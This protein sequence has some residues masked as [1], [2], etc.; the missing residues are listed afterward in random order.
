VNN[1]KEQHQK[2][3]SRLDKSLNKYLPLRGPTPSNPKRT[4][5]D[6][7]SYSRQVV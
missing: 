3:M 4:E 7:V 2:E 6:K 1:V 5:M